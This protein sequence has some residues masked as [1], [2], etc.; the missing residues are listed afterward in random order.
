MRQSATEPVIARP[1]QGLHEI[2]RD[3]VRWVEH[4]RILMCEH[5]HAPHRRQIAL[6]LIGH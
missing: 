6:H 2:T 3:V 4:Q 5:R 1:G